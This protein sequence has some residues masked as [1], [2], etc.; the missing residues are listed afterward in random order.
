MRKILLLGG[1]GFIGK[2]IANELALNKENEVIIADRHI[3]EN[4]KLKNISFKK[5]NFVNCDDFSSFLDGVDTV[6]HL[7]S[8]INPS[9]DISNIEKEIQENIFPTLKLLENMSQCHTRK[10][11][12]VSSGGTIYG[13]H[14]KGSIS[15]ITRTNPICNYGILK[16]LIEKY[17]FM[18]H[19][20]H[21]IE[22][23]V[24][25]LSN[26]YSE[27][28]K[29]GKSQGIIPI[30]I[31]QLLNNEVVN[32]W[33]NGEDV[34]DYIYINDAISAIVKIINYDGKTNVFNVGTGIGHTVNEVL[35][36]LIQKLNIESPN[37]CYKNSR[38]CDVKNNVLDIK[39]ISKT[40]N[41]V[42]E[43]SLEDGID[44][45]IRKKIKRGDLK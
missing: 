40:L 35:N 12:F 7:I 23:K 21:G 29:S 28:T 42:P 17:L 44:R 38:K 25:R 6:V 1:N 16:D 5:I 24:I 14:S 31:D 39:K 43:V 8:T 2:Y 9:D 11:V 19:H 45:V 20:Y 34:R 27:I 36:M 18:F 32:V 22:Y 4:L 13:E 15:E 37:I 10:I 41:W 26:P 30:F 33:G 3:D